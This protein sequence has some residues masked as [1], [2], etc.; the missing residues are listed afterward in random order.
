MMHSLNRKLEFGV[1]FG[2][3]HKIDSTSVVYESAIELGSDHS[4]KHLLMTWY[5][6]LEGF[7]RYLSTPAK[8]TPT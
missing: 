5:L 8:L 1:V 3:H 4:S 6:F 2:L 7:L